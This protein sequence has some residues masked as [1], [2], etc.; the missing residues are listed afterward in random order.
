MSVYQQN[1]RKICR[2]TSKIRL[3]IIDRVTRK[4]FLMGRVLQLI[5]LGCKKAAFDFLLFT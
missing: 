1:M 2:S 3:K 4:P 5:Q